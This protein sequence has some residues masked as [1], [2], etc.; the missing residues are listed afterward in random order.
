M[1]YFEFR[2]DELALG[3]LTSA[4]AK[5]HVKSAY[6]LGILLLY[7]SDEQKYMGSQIIS[8]W[9]RHWLS[10]ELEAYIF[11][12]IFLFDTVMTDRGHQMTISPR[13]RCCHNESHR[14]YSVDD[15]QYIYLFPGCIL[16]EADKELHNI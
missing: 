12:D 3:L 4:S 9:R 16:C 7:G 2:N 14:V 1:N 15:Q 13:P 5:G 11:R 10:D 6:A 8:D